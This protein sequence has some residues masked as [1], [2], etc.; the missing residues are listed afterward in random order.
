MS[1]VKR[2]LSGVATG[3]IYT[4]VTSLVALWLTPYTL[5]F[6]DRTHYG[7]YILLA[8][9]LTWLNLLQLTHKFSFFYRIYG[10][11]NKYYILLY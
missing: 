8:D 10:I 7:Y 2:Y 4:I 6:V 5:G 11:R 9:I 3:Y 1:N